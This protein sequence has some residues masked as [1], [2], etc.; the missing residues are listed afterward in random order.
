MEKSRKTK[1]I[2]IG[3]AVVCGLLITIASLV[4]LL[5]E[6][7]NYFFSREITSDQYLEQILDMA[8]SGDTEGIRSLYIEG[9]ADNK[10]IDREIQMIM[11]TWDGSQEYTFKKTGLSINTNSSNGFKTKEVECTY[12]IQTDDN[13]KLVMQLE[14]AELPNG[15][16]GLVSIYMKHMGTLAPQG[17]LTT[18]GQWNIL[19]WGLFF[20]SIAMIVWT[21]VTAVICCRQRPRYRWV[22]LALILLAYLYVGFYVSAEEGGHMLRFEWRAAFIGFSK[23]LRYTNQS[24]RFRLCLPVGTIVYWLMKKKLEQDKESGYPKGE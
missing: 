18:I 1:W 19:Q 4:F 13:Q 20:L 11:D 22:W 14:R 15:E 6:G 17:S 7:I 23:F 2:I 10:Q 21:A 8:E 24:I 16:N 5:F 12:R 9:T 3:I